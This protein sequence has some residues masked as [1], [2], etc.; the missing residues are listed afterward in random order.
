MPSLLRPVRIRDR[1]EAHRASTPLELLFDLCFVVAIAVLAAELHY[2]LADGHVAAGIAG[3]LLV[4]VPVWWAWMSYTWYA[5]AFDN[6]DVLFR[7]L[8]LLQMAG[9]LVLAA[10]V[11]SL[12]SGNPV[13]FTLAY[14]A[15]RVPLVIQWLRAARDDVGYRRF[16]LRYAIG[17]VAAQGVWLLALA[18]PTP[19]RWAVWGTALAL[20]LLT[21]IWS[22]RVSPERAFHAG[23]IAERY[24]L[25]TIIVLGESILSVSIG[26][27]DALDV[28][29]ID[30]ATVAICASALV[31]AFGVWWLYFDTL[32]R[33]ALE[34][35]RRAAFTWGYGHA[36]LYASI[37]A[38]GAGT[39][40]QLDGL[41]PQVWWFAVPV[42]LGLLS[43]A[44]LQQSAN[45]E[46]RSA[47]LLTITVL[48]LI[49]AATALQS[50]IAVADAAVAVLV[51][52]AVGI[53][54]WRRRGSR[55]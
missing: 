20:E 52:V 8:T 38:I 25:F 5:T 16:A 29:S 41:A 45:V 51:L 31:A 23:H 13:P 26:I 44:W 6:D 11:P 33:K 24:G 7:V 28:G 30:T 40:A 15:M 32:G 14:T 47:A 39:Q 9:V 46:T 10:S 55:S 2:G 48:A 1:T 36:L 49:G 53:E 54:T 27:R 35:H 12:Q 43:M 37:A 22:T 19:G 18:V 4:F 42:G 50:H 3:Y 34:R 21:P 17:I